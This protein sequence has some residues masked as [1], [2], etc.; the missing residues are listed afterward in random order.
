MYTWCCMC[1]LHG[2]AKLAACRGEHDV[3]WQVIKLLNTLNLR[4]T[5]SFCEA[6]CIELSLKKHCAEL[7]RS[8][9]VRHV[10]A[11]WHCYI[12]GMQSQGT[13]IKLS[14]VSGTH[15]HSVQAVEAPCTELCP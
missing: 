11:I 13:N 7:L 14:R 3:R 12:S 6:P 2:C 10:V 8:S 4:N 15:C 5:L 1:V 9:A